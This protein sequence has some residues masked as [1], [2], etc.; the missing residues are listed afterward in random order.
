MPKKLIQFNTKAFMHDFGKRMKTLNLKLRNEIFDQIKWDLRD[1]D[2]K[3]NP[4]NILNQ[5]PT[6]DAKR[7]NAVLQS[8]ATDQANWITSTHLKSTI[9]ALQDNFKDTSV[10]LYYE[11]GTGT[12][13]DKDATY[14]SLGDPNPFRVPG[15]GAPIVTRSRHRGM[16]S[17]FAKNG[18]G[19][20]WKDAGGNWRVTYSQRGG[21]G[22]G[23]EGF[24][25][26]IG[27]D[28]EAYHWFSKA[29]AN[30]YLKKRIQ[31]LFTECL[32]KP[33]PLKLSTYFTLN[34][35]TLGKD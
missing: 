25:K 19:S 16:T 17:G 33:A 18:R 23:S 14:E 10:G 20:I 29:F 26:Y 35:F 22:A 15:T 9:H 5:E 2:F 8:L 3:T 7:K 30:P 11:Y 4:V 28:V 1:I 32:S 21:E 13:M 34:D 31:A 6:S 27:E 24:T 12:E